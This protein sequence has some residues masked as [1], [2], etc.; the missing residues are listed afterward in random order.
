MR[1]DSARAAGL[2]EGKVERIADG[3]ETEFTEAETAALNLTDA[4]IGDPRSLTDAH[5]DAL[6]AHF[7]DAEIIELTLGVGLFLAMSK[8]LINLGLE[9]EDM[10]VTLIPTPGS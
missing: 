9:P 1:F 4:I 5:R 3:Y 8:V 6:K 2:E 7:S 10:P